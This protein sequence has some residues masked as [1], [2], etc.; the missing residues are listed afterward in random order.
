MTNM[1]IGSWQGAGAL[2]VIPMST[3]CAGALTWL[4]RLDL[5]TSTVARF[6]RL[7]KGGR[8]ANQRLARST[9]PPSAGARGRRN[10][11][12]MTP[13]PSHSN[14]AT[15]VG[16]AADYTILLCC[17]TTSTHI[18]PLCN[19]MQ[20]FELRCPTKWKHMVFST[21]ECGL[22]HIEHRS[23]LSRLMVFGWC[24]S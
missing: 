23:S 6:T 9:P 4:W 19:G 18:T 21:L 8:L 17:A 7:W 16:G 11:F 13:I 2:A 20:C 10:G 5:V 15:R 22:K 12:E 1:Q 14:V 3:I 24:A